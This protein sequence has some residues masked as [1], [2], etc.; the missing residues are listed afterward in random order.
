MTDLGTLGGASSV[1]YDINE[2]GLV[3]GSSRTAGNGPIHAFLWKNGV[4]VDLG[5]LGGTGA[6]SG[7]GLRI[8]SAAKTG[9]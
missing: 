6:L 9:I 1:P 7:S 3:V 8:Q 2:A 5:T 4:L